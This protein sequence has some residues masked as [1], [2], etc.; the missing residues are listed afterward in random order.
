MFWGEPQFRW[1]WMSRVLWMVQNSG[2][3]HLG[4]NK[5]CKSWDRLPT[6][7]VVIVWQKNHIHFQRAVF[8]GKNPKMRVA[9]PHYFVCLVGDFF[10]R[11]YHGKSSFN[12]NL[13]EYFSCV[14]TTWEV[15]FWIC[16]KCPPFAGLIDRLIN[17]NCWSLTLALAW[18]Y[19]LY[20]HARYTFKM[21]RNTIVQ[22]R[23]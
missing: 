9:K 6:S 8:T 19:K 7:T 20:T 21:H 23:T 14:P 16:D 22:T 18:L 1:P 4:C 11:F 13:V 3:H 17:L 15:S 10:D 12:Q 5:P 2:D